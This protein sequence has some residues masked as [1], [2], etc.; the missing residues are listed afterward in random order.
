MDFQPEVSLPTSAVV[1]TQSSGA[2]RKGILI[3][4]VL[5]IIVVGVGIGFWL[6]RSKVPAKSKE[7][8]LT[9]WGLWEP[10]NIMSPLFQEFEALNPN[11]KIDYRLQSAN[12]YRER[13]TTFL[14]KNEEAPDIF[15]IHNTWVPIF[16]QQLSPVPASIFSAADFEESFFPAAKTD[17]RFGNNYVA[18]PLMYDGLAMYV[19]DELLA[20][21]GKPV[22]ELWTD[23][24]KTAIELS[25]C[26]SEDGKCSS[27][28]RILVSGVAMGATENVDH[29]QEIL[30]TLMLQNNVNLNSPTAAL[31]EEPLKFFTVFN[32]GDHIWDSSL[33]S[34]TTMFANGKLVFYFAPS[35]RIFEIRQMA[36]N[37]KFSIYPM[38]Q[39]ALD[40]ARG[41]KPVT[42]ASYWA[43]GVNKQSPNV[44][45]AWKLVKFL[46]SKESLTKAYQ[47]ASLVRGFGE[48]YPYRDM[49]ESLKT[50]PLV[51][52]FA[53]QADSARTWYL[54]SNTFDGVGGINSRL[55]VY[56]ADAINTVNQGG[57]AAE[58]IK[59]LSLGINQVLSQY[60]ITNP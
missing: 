9:Y 44:D 33:P 41:E 47:A 2:P 8:T 25:A 35:W 55:S 18:I 53:S 34:S 50:T 15:R 30:T 39:L 17:L 51:G 28:K 59:T 16:K 11:I 13:L 58:A 57:G 7:I 5:F 23:L 29:W 27:G 52:A 36:P 37:L 49:I 21:G 6:T 26:D 31:A 43:E 20:Q 22:P 3:G 32:S 45:A 4:I 19:N 14:S 46:S 38:P 42:L 10:D 24:R 48:I 12:E 54:A 56:F 60:G 40:S 1:N